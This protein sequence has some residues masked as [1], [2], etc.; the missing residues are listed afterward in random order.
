MSNKPTGAMGAGNYGKMMNGRGN[1]PKYRH[2]PHA[3][4]WAKID[5]ERAEMQKRQQDAIIEA[6]V[7]K[8]LAEMASNT[9]TAS[10]VPSKKFE[11]EE[12]SKVLQVM[13][14]LGD[15]EQ[16]STNGIVLVVND[17]KVVITKA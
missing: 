16:A 11:G 10:E 1:P 7:K 14:T 6:E 8:R 12:L 4:A 17:V 9:E 3:E 2:L 5:A 15:M 13:S